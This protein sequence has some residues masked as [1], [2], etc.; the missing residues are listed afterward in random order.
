[1]NTGVKWPEL[2]VLLGAELQ[3]QCRCHG[4]KAGAVCWLQE[5]A[6]KELAGCWRLLATLQTSSTA[7]PSGAESRYKRP[8]A[9]IVHPVITYSIPLCP[10]PGRG[11]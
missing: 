4:Q 5:D 11:I 10:K 1:M 2:T 7:R 3:E 8:M 6:L 9:Q